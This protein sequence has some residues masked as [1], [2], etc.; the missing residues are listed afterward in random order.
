M[1]RF[2]E[3]I[4]DYYTQRDIHYSG[5]LPPSFIPPRPPLPLHIRIVCNAGY[6]EH[7]GPLFKRLG[8][9]PFDELIKYSQ[10][11]FMHY[12]HH[13][14]LPLSFN[15][16]WFGYQTEIAIRNLLCRTQK[17]YMYPAIIMPQPKVFYYLRFLEHGMAQ[18]PS[19][20][21][22]PSVSS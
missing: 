9:L 19:N 4:K 1:Y 16:T 11:K 20:L 12:F 21:I 10:L 22:Y 5:Y 14:K 15:E 13:G 17:S 7:T 18:T 8:I 6:R 2:T 3:T